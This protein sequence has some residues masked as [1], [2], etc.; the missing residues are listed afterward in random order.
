VQYLVSY[1]Q[2]NVYFNRLK[3]AGANCTELGGLTNGIAIMVEYHH[4]LG[5]IVSGVNRDPFSA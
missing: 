5:G 3:T 1:N 2:R 4:A